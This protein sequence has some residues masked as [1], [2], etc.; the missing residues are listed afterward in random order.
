MV[1]VIVVVFVIVAVAM[2][3]LAEVT[4]PAESTV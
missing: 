2:V 3:K 1:S 4:E